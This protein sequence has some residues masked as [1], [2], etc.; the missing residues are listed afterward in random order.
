VAFA[1]DAFDDD[2]QL[3]D[4]R[5]ADQLRVVVRQLIDYARMLG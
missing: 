5:L 1:A 3:K 2:D 4:Q